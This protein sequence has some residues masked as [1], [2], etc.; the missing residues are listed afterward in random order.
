MVDNVAQQIYSFNQT[1]S[2]Q[3]LCGDPYP[4]IDS[5]NTNFNDSVFLV[6]FTVN[7]TQST[8]NIGF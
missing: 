7:H 6:D 8:L 5:F 4:T 2:T 1:S 3:N